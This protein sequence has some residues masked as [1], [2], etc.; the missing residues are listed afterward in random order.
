MR[1]LRRG[2]GQ[3]LKLSRNG[4]FGGGIGCDRSGDVDVFDQAY[5][6]AL[7]RAKTEQEERDAE[8]ITMMQMDW[9]RGRCIGRVI[10]SMF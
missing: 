10:V 4:G 6:E 9:A 2:R 5:R 1:W 3:P 8:R 7:A